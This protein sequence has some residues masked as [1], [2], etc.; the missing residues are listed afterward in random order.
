MSF[1]FETWQSFTRIVTLRLKSI[2]LASCL[3]HNRQF[4]SKSIKIGLYRLFVLVLVFI[5]GVFDRFGVP[6]FLGVD[7]VPCIRS[8]S[9]LKSGLTHR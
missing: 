5:R 7:K 6:L 4:L 1:D 2:E 3:S 8:S 9:R